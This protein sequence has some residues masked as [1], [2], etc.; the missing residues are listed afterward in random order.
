VTSE[1]LAR[2]LAEQRGRI[3]VFAPEGGGLFAIMA[4]RYSTGSNFEIY[5]KAHAGD[6][7]RVDRRHAEPIYVPRPTLT[8]AVTMQPAVLH[9]L[10]ETP[11]FRG[12]GLLARFLYGFP[13]SPLGDRDADPAPLPEHV[14]RDYAAGLREL[15][16]LQPSAAEA[17]RTVPHTVHLSPEGRERWLAFVR[18]L[19]PRLGEAGDLH[20]VADWAAKLPGAVI[21][22]A[23]LLHCARER[24]Q[25]WARPIAAATMRDAVAI[26]DYLLP[27][28][29]AAF[30]TMGTDPAVAEAEYLLGHIRRR[31]VATLTKRDLFQWTRGHFDQVAELEPA[32]AVLVAHNYLRPMPPPKRDGPGRPASPGFAVN[33]AVHTQNPQNS[34]QRVDSEDSEDA[35]RCFRGKWRPAEGSPDAGSGPRV[36]VEPVPELPCQLADLW[37]EAP[38]VEPVGD[39]DLDLESPPAELAHLP[40]RL[41]ARCGGPLTHH[42]S[43]PDAGW[44]CHRCYPDAA[45]LLVAAPDDGQRQSY[46]AEEN[47]ALQ[48]VSDAELLR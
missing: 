11:E 21:R 48:D 47:E 17:G 15:L 9:G 6:P 20:T 33:P 45:Q 19:E 13:L 29:R 44:I 46:V 22:L 4:G 26:S 31:A 2:L 39:D 30:R 23:G 41:C 37:R 16:A 35:L 25:P 24:S 36:T 5:L 32:L 1:A 14:E 3:S 38:L 34:A 43:R 28:A 18:A 27:H 12:R 7:L 40:E 8:L 10:H 42:G